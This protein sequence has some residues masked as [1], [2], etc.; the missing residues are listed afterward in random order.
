VDG[1]A[2]PNQAVL[3][4][5]VP[6]QVVPNQVLLNQ[7]AKV[8][9]LANHHHHHRLRHHQVAVALNQEQKLVNEFALVGLPEKLADKNAALPATTTEVQLNPHGVIKQ[10]QMK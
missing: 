2:V 3:N 4:Q 8:D 6:N 10:A 5:T 7:V 9:G 1:L